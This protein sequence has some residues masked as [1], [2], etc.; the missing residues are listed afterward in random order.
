MAVR[1]KRLFGPTLLVAAA[2]DHVVFTCPPDTTARIEVVLMVNVSAGTATCMLG[3]G[4]TNVGDRLTPPMSAPTANW[5]VNP[6]LIVLHGG[7]QLV[8]R[9]SVASAFT[10][11]GHGSLLDGINDL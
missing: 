5:A 1:T 11:S 6:Y 9:Q 7:E 10:V 4:T 8:A 2:T 3:K